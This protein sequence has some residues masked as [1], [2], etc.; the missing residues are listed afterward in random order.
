M[1]FQYSCQVEDD[2]S[3][4]NSYLASVKIQN[5][6][7]LSKKSGTRSN[8]PSLVARLMGMDM[9]PLDTKSVVPSDESISENMV[10]D[11]FYQDIEDDGWGQN[12]GKPRPREH[13]QEEEFQTFKKEFEAYQAARFKECLKDSGTGSISS[14]MHAQESLNKEMVP[15]Y[16][17][18]Q[19]E[20]TEKSAELDSHLFKTKLPN[21]DMMNLRDRTLSRDFEESL[22]LNTRSRLD[23]CSSPS[24]IVILKP[25]A[26]SIYNCYHKD[27]GTSSSGTL[28]GRGSI[29]EFLEEVGERLKCEMQGKS[30]KKGSAG[31]GSGIETPY[32]EKL[33]DPKEIAHYIAQEVRE[34]VTRDAEVT[35]IRS[36]STQKPFSTRWSRIPEIFNRD[37]RNFFTKRLRN[38]MKNEAL[39]DIPEMSCGNSRSYI[40]DNHCDILKERQEIQTGSFRH[41]IDNNSFLHKELSSQKL[42][43][44]LSA[45]AVSR[46]AFEKL[47]AV[48]TMPVKVKKQKK[49]RFKFIEKVSSFKHAFDLRRKLFGSRVHSMVE[50]HCNEYDPLV[51][52]IRSGP[53]V[54][55]KYGERHVSLL[56]PLSPLFSN[57]LHILFLSNHHSFCL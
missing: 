12:Y 28:Q 54:L 53:T 40:L 5:N 34:S 23:I 52:D 13:P 39:F 29:E 8:A 21:D 17:S 38:V 27:N 11:P 2:W 6:E 31:R 37:T 14:Q 3:K 33:S 22:I 9:M 47:E 48:E 43:R 19:R 46:R 50:S 26:D 36:K 4:I 42:V 16:E 55:L 56:Y 7:K 41:E 32:Y 15:H 44:S 1:N 45:P 49:D 35:L 18:S 24:Q 57:I 25:S 30:V 51:R 10:F 20:A